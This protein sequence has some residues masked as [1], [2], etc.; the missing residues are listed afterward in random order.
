MNTHF[1]KRLVHRRFSIAAGVIVGIATAS[2][3]AAWFHNF[4][5]YLDEK[6]SAWASSGGE[7]PEQRKPARLYQPRVDYLLQRVRLNGRV[8]NSAWQSLREA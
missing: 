5:P 2:A 6:T 3:W 8:G 4:A 1:L 7:A